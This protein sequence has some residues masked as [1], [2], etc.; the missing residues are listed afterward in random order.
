[1]LSSRPKKRYYWYGHTEDATFQGSICLANTLSVCETKITQTYE[2]DKIG[3]STGVSTFTRGGGWK[4]AFASYPAHCYLGSLNGQSLLLFLSP[5][6]CR[7]GSPPSAWLIASH[8][9][10]YGPGPALSPAAGRHAISPT[11]WVVPPVCIEVTPPSVSPWS[12]III[13]WY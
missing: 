7:A 11:C 12:F 4:P 6:V 9:G 8:Q 1:M 3:L 10:V 13:N 5:S 2:N